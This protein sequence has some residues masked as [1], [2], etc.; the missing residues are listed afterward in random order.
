MKKT[1]RY[2]LMTGILVTGLLCGCGNAIP[3]MTA[4]QEQAV[5][6]YAAVTLLKYDAN[7]RSRLVDLADYP[8]EPEA[9][10][11][12]PA[13]E[14]QEPEPEPEPAQPS[15]NDAPVESAPEE[16]PVADQSMEGFLGLADGISLQL[17]GYAMQDSY[18]DDSIMGGFFSLT[19]SE[20]KKL[21]I[22]HYTLHN[23][24][25]M[26]QSIDFLYDEITF[27]VRINGEN[28][29]TALVTMLEDDMSTYM[30]TLE[31]GESKELALIF[32]VEENLDGAISSVELVMKSAS[33]T[34]TKM[35]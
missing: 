7:H 29:K 15:I 11:P 30:G 8:L 34:F 33:D 20:G 14:P 31:S 32:E 1:G 4:E 5:G 17:N 6:E 27:K 16:T 3:L 12:Q 28:A 21:M 24:S 35:L 13:A 26:A 23:G 18:P 22:I 9:P 10:A 19:A 2:N 25:G